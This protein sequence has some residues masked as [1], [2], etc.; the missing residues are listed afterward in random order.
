MDQAPF[1]AKAPGEN[2]R[3]YAYRVLYNR[4]MTLDF[5]PG[6]LLVDAELSQALRVSRTPIREAIVSLVESKLVTVQP[7]RSS[8]VSRIDL[9]AVEE[10]VFLRYH[11]ECAIFR[12]AVKK[13]DGQ[14]IARLRA[15]IEQQKLCL[16]T[17]DLDGYMELDNAFHKLLYFAARKPWTWATVMRIVTHHDPGAPPAGA[18]GHRAA[19]AR[20]RGALRAAARAR[21]AQRTG[22]GRLPPRA[23][24]GRV[25]RRAAGADAALSRLFRRLMAGRSS[26]SAPP[27]PDETRAPRPLPRG[28]L[29]T[30]PVK[31]AMRSA[32]LRQRALH[33]LGI[34]HGGHGVGHIAVRPRC[35]APRPP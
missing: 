10:G 25:P 11:A 9:D 18:P 8:M 3:E 17:G 21:H 19:L 12:E 26:A 13:A 4:I 31:R 33:A 1:P 6:M 20:A 32:P 30:R 7:Q 22:H 5:P 34:A 24:D 28:A 29:R 2:A 27:R 16:Q 23:P 15:N 35:A 14:D